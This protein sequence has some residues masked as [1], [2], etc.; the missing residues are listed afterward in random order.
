[1][2]RFTISLFSIFGLLF[3]PFA[4]AMAQTFPGF[5]M[6]IYGIVTIDSV[7]AGTD[8]VVKIYNGSVAAENLIDNITVGASGAYGGGTA[9]DGKLTIPATATG[10]LVF[11]VTETDRVDADADVETTVATASLTLTTNVTGDC[12][13]VTALS[14]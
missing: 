1:M 10:T 5:P 14:A 12:P 8:T 6:A 7:N 11:T 9:T 3:I 2:R 13:A 4:P